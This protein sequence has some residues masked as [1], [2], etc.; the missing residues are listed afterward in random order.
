ALTAERL[1]VRPADQDIRPSGGG[2]APRYRRPAVGEKEDDVEVV[3][4]EGERTEGDGHEGAAQKGTGDAPER[5]PS[6][7]AVDAG[8]FVDLVGYR[9]QRSQRGREHERQAQP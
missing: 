4:V 2:R 7:S 1:V 6:V 8:R 3:E 9:R 5:G